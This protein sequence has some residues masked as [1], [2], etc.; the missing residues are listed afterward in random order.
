MTTFQR[1]LLLSL[2]A[3][4]PL[5]QADDIV[6]T[7]VLDTVV[8]SGR[9]PGPGMWKVS[10]DDRVLW[11]LGTVAPLPKRMQWTSDEV[12]ATIARSQEVLLPPSVTMRSDIGRVRALFLLPSLMKARNNPDGKLL[13]EVVPE[14][15]YARWAVL[16]R[17]HLGRDRGVEKRR[18]IIAAQQLQEA[19]LK[20]HDLA[21]DNLA[22]RVARQAAKRHKVPT[23][24]PSVVITIA[25][26][27]QTLRE[28]SE[29]MLDDVECFG[30]TLERLETQTDTMKL[31][32]NAWALGEIE[33]LR[34]LTLADTYR[35][36]ADALLETRIARDQGFDDL[37][38]QIDAAWLEA[39][40]RALAAN[41]STFA[42]LPM[43]MLVGE[44]GFLARFETRG[45]QVEAPQRPAP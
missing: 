5:A 31:R 33:L 19:A 16:K 38:A 37:E 35:A 28:F 17:R 3:S 2:L 30:R 12:E 26:A 27:R 1:A 20:D 44:D 15:L 11:L 13:S 23:S 32:A 39:A 10:K 22:A 8:V 36:C 18:P 45:Y 29:S 41:A 4:L 42:V 9:Q 24:T 40:E 14:P 21:F 43:A 34:S 25:N 6:P 7:T